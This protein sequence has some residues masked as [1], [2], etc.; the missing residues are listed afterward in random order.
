M[1]TNSYKTKIAKIKYIVVFNNDSYPLY[2]CNFDLKQIVLINLN[3]NENG[4]ELYKIGLYH[5]K[6]RI[7]IPL[8]QFYINFE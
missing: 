3:S 5:F 1:S 4:Q 7:S 8:I 6:F 2:I